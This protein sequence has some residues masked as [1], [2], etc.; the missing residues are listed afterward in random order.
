LKDSTQLLAEIEVLR[1][2]LG[3]KL[4]CLLIKYLKE[5]QSKPKNT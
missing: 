2:Q 5:Q 4:D 1:K 3:K